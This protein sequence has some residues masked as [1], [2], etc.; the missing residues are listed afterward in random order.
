MRNT[1]AENAEWIA[2]II[3]RYLDDPKKHAIAPSLSE[4][5]FGEPLIGFGNGKDPVFRQL[6][7]L[8]GPFYWTPEEIFRLSLP[9]GFEIVDLNPQ[10]R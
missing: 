6:K 3:H 10:E 5:A 9:P 1:V 8:I 4:P 2:S 7:K